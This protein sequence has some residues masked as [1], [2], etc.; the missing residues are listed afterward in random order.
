MTPLRQRMTE[1][2]QVR[3]LSA[4]TQNSYLQQVSLLTCFFQN[5]SNVFGEK[6]I[7]PEVLRSSA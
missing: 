2:M 4:H 6:L 5:G 3:N 1:D 7:C